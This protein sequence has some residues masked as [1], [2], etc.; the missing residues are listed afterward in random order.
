MGCTPGRISVAYTVSD[1]A[2]DT[3]ENGRSVL[4]LE[5]LGV[6]QP[7]QPG[8]ILLAGHLPVEGALQ[9]G[10]C[11]KSWIRMQPIEEVKAEDLDCTKIL[12]AMDVTVQHHPFSGM[13]ADEETLERLLADI[14][15]LPRPLMIQCCTGAWA[16]AV[17]LLQMA[18]ERGCSAQSVQQ[19]AEDMD[20]K[21]FT[22]CTTCGPIREWLLKRLPRGQELNESSSK[23]EKEGALV[24][25]M[26]DPTSCTFTYIIGCR[27]TGETVLLDPVLEQMDRDLRIVD[28]L[29]FRLKYVL[30]THVHADHVTSGACIR[31][32]RPR[33]RT[34]ISEDSTAEADL[35]VKHGDRISVGEVELEVRATPGHTAGCLTYVL[36]PAGSPAI[37]FT[38]DTLL[39]RGC[40]RTDFQEGSSERLYESVHSQIFSLPE[41]TLV[42]PA[43][44]YKGRNVSTVGEEKRYNLRLTKSKQEFIKLMSELNLPYPKKMDIA[45]PANLICGVQDSEAEVFSLQF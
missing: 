21:F 42:Y 8:D 4:Q 30:N 27:K 20:L 28:N 19:L 5:T 41:G 6:E 45:V 12:A 33:V 36:R 3:V 18:L 37:A 35:K 26:F 34:I 10:K 43:H 15:R 23:Q 32:A 9:L 11:L 13:E 44:D 2:Q 25:Q 40:G 1:S 7:V 29:G 31:D 39:I 38:G 22:R 24:Q 14:K 16:G 17:M